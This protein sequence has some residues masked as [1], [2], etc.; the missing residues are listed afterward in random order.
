MIY[1]LIISVFLL[2][3]FYSFGLLFQKV[4]PQINHYF[5]LTIL[6]GMIGVGLISFVLAFVIPLNFTYE[7]CLIVLALFGL[8]YYRK[9]SI[10][11]LKFFKTIPSP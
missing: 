2:F 10:E 8:I 4:L 6:N 5:S 1:Q 3:Y 11:F 7:I 9:R